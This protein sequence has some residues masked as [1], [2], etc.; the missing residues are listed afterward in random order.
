MVF[1]FAPPVFAEDAVRQ[2]AAAGELRLLTARQLTWLHSF[3][4]NASKNM[5]D[6]AWLAAEA[7]NARN[8][9]L[10]NTAAY[11]ATAA[12]VLRGEAEIV[13]LEKSWRR[14][15][16][17]PLLVILHFD[18]SAVVD[19]SVCTCDPVRQKAVEAAIGNFARDLDRSPTRTITRIANL[20]FRA[21]RGAE[22][23]WT[24]SYLPFDTKLTPVVGRTWVVYENM[25]R[26]NWWG[27]AIRPIALRVLPDAADK[28]TAE[29]MVAW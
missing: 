28:A 4:S 12:A 6:A 5:S 23:A 7:T 24:G 2:I 14:T 16:D 9:G 13:D 22:K 19:V 3:E 15:V 29:A 17:D 8:A 27:E 18:Q 25:I 10:P 21:G 11:L 26:A 1:L 20:Q